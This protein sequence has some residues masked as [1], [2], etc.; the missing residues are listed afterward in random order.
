MQNTVSLEQLYAIR[1]KIQE[2]KEKCDQ[3][4]D[5]YSHWWVDLPMLPLYT[6]RS[7]LR[8]LPPPWAG[9]G[10][11]IFFAIW[12]MFL[13]LWGGGLLGGLLFGL[14][15]WLRIKKYSES[16]QG[17]AYLF[18]SL[19]IAPV[20][21]MV[22]LMK[23]M[24]GGSWSMVLILGFAA[25]FLGG[26]LMVPAKVKANVQIREENEARMQ[27]NE[28]MKEYNSNLQELISYAKEGLAALRGQ[29]SDLIRRYG[30]PPD[31]ASLHAVNKFIEYVRNHQGDTYAALISEYKKDVHNQAMLEEKRRQTA[32]LQQQEENQRYQIEL[33]EYSNMLQAAQNWQL[34]E[35]N[36]RLENID[37]NL[38]SLRSRV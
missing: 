7:A 12:L 33:S 36:D 32:I 23:L 37:K 10:L 31:Y 20:I 25:W 11:G 13:D 18:F 29:L 28:Q 9:H 22:A 14:C 6:P 1:D 19:L 21:A 8:D 30:Y 4:S 2:V 15:T 24:N 27:K 38:A 26:L 35:A 5:L 3:I 16:W 17:K 34:R